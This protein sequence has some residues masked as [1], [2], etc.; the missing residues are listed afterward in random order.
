M[1]SIFGSQIGNVGLIKGRKEADVPIRRMLLGVLVIVVSAAYERTAAIAANS[2]AP[3]GLAGMSGH[4][5]VGADNAPD[6][7]SPSTTFSLTTTVKPDTTHL[8]F[9]NTTSGDVV[10]WVMNGLAAPAGALIY[11]GLPLAWRID[12]IGDLDG[13]FKADLVFRNTETGDVA[14]WLLDVPAIKQWAVVYPGLDLSWE[15]DRVG[16]LNGDGK[17]DLVFRNTQSGDVAGWLMNGLTLAEGG[18]ISASLP[19]EWRIDGM[20]DLNGDGR[21]DLV[22]RNTEAGDVVGWLMNGLTLVEGGMISASLPLEWRIDGMGD[23]NGDG[24]GDLLFRHTQAGDVFGW[25]MNGLTLAQ[26]GMIY[27]GLA[28]EWRIDGMADLNGDARADLVL[29]HTAGDV[30]GWLMNG[31]TL[32]DWGTIYARLP[33]EWEIEGSGDLVNVV[34]PGAIYVFSGPLDSVRGFTTRS[35]YVFYDN[36]V[37]ELRYEGFAPLRAMYRQDSAT[38]TFRFD[39]T[40]TWDQ[41]WSCLSDSRAT[42]GIC[43]FATGTLRGDLLE[44]RYGDSMQHADFENAVYRRS[45]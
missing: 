22:F 20:G 6:V 35:Q 36:G 34:E 37:F 15:I 23:L 30:A 43:P 27:P 38:I 9:R 42:H 31:L 1:R 12:G 4:Q 32:A 25:L 33:L 16:D 3:S 14:A 13:D 41:G 29:R 18:M 2:I 19:L 24:R 11:A 10:A 5:H 7:S 21:A 39:D 17:A 28:L 45:Q 8:V 26:G 40:W 44:V